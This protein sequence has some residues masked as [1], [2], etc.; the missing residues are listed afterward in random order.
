MLRVLYERESMCVVQKQAH[1]L[2][3][4]SAFTK[5]KERTLLD[6]VREHFSSDYVPVH[7]LDRQTSGCIM[8]AQK[9]Q[10]HFWQGVLEQE[11]SQKE[12]IALVRGHFRKTHEPFVLE[13]PLTSIKGVKQNA[14]TIFES[15]E[16][17]KS[18]RLS[19]VCAKIVSGRTHQVRK[20]LK[21]LSHPIIGDANYGKGALNRSIRD[22]Y[23]LSRLALHA[24]SLCF[25]DQG[26]LVAVQAPLP[27]DLYE[28][29]EKLG[30][31]QSP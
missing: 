26:A 2:V 10:A 16:N 12:Y 22:K 19:W 24:R 9:G 25:L 3:H 8:F 1:I 7:R 20:H 6:E 15:I 14:C 27:N 21:H 30:F 17:A 29:F 18:E 28:P 11:Q 13:H 31:S 4:N 23:G 5:T